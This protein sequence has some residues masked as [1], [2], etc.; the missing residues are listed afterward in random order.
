MYRTPGRRSGPL[1]APKTMG[2]FEGI[3]TEPL[4]EGYTEADLD[5]RFDA[6]FDHYGIEC[7]NTDDWTEES[8]LRLDASKWEFL[9]TLL[10]FDILTCMWG[11]RPVGRPWK[12]DF[13]DRHRNPE[14]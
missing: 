5:V 9:A 7:P 13:T 12:L 14:N 1:R 3:L 4:P 8:R 11:A 10:V 6:L 2:P